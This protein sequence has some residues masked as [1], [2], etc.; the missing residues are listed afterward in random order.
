MRLAGTLIGGGAV[1][2]L[3]VAA[4]PAGAS[5]ETAPAARVTLADDV[6]APPARVRRWEYVVV[7]RTSSDQPDAIGRAEE[8][9]F[10]AGAAVLDRVRT[11]FAPRSQDHRLLVRLRD[12]D[13]LGTV[14]RAMQAQQGVLGATAVPLP[15]TPTVAGGPSFMLAYTSELSE[16]TA[17][18]GIF[19]H[20]EVPPILDKRDLLETYSVP[21]G[22][23]AG[24]SPQVAGGVGLN[25]S[26]MIKRLKETSWFR[27]EQRMKR[28]YLPILPPSGEASISEP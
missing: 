27:R 3:A 7:V 10:L 19:V 11:D 18:P 24:P 12:K 2:A 14:L 1:L 6:S 13:K 4:T 23:A 22:P 5:V 21:V 28:A 15:E 20:H 8:A 16:G 17:E 25:V 26:A 9:A